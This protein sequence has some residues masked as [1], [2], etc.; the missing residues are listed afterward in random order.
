MSSTLVAG[1]GN[2]FLGDDGFGSEVA[3]RLAET[4]LPADV[5][6][7]DIGIRGVH[8][9]YQ[10]LNGYETLILI[11]AM[12]RG[13]QPGTIT[14]LET[15]LAAHADPTGAGPPVDPHSMGPD[16]VLRLLAGL[17]EPLGAAV[18]RVLIVG[19]EPAA[20]GRHGAVRA[21]SRRSSDR[22]HDD[23]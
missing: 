9:A 19:C 2:I 3:Q 4:A 14:V 13:E 16:A 21:G 5:E 8:L 12:R 11:D 7:S 18:R 10:L 22:C 20:R 17:A 6:V 23:R 15:T 1:I